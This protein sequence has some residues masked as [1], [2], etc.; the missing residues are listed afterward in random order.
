VDWLRHAAVETPGAPAIVA[1]GTEISYEA[2]DRGADAVAGVVGASGIGAGDAVAVWGQNTPGTVA[3]VWGIPRSGATAVMLPTG[4]P[5]AEA[6]RLTRL[7]GARGLWGGGDGPDL[8]RLL[9]SPSAARRAPRGGPP[10]GDARYVV[11]TSGSSAPRRGVILTGSQIEASARASADRLESSASDRWLCV[12]PLGHVGGLSILWRQARVGGAVVLHES[13]DAA[14]VAD[15]LDGQVTLA[16]VVPTMLRRIVAG[17]QRPFAGLRAVLVG[18]GP[19][20]VELLVAARTRGIPALQTYGMTETASQVCTEDPGDLGPPGTAGRPL[21]GVDIRTVDE[22]G[23]PASEGVVEVRGAVVS[24]GDI[25]GTVRAPNAWMRT[26]DLGRLD[27]SGRLRVL[28]RA[29]RV[30]VTGGENVHPS[31]VEA[32]LAG[33]PGV[34]AVRVTG[35]PD[36]EWGTTVVARVVADGVDPADLLDVARARLAAHEVPK[37]IEIVDRLD[38]SWKDA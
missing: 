20:D 36:P 19:A 6:M 5:A 3:A 7:A 25:D 26:G 4:L 30:I 12:L 1:D 22:D 31:T 27:A 34:S 17:A 24:P 32:A 37:R 10:D 33:V 15:A 23:N 11:F 38:G 9:A 13:F 35:E 21:D 16:S 14:A 2:L 28:G 18:G 8:E 29:D